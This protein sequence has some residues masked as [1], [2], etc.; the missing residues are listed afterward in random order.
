M[1]IKKHIKANMKNTFLGLVFLATA[2]AAHAQSWTNRYAGSVDTWG[3]A[4]A[5]DSSGNAIVTGRVDGTNALTIKY[6]SAGVPLWT[7]RCGGAL[8]SI[9]VDGSGNVFVRSDG[10]VIGKYS[11]S[12][13][14]LWT[15]RYEGSANENGVARCSAVDGK[16][17]VVVTGYSGGDGNYFDFVTIKYSGSGTALWTNRYDGPANKGD[18]AEYVAV[19]SS[20]NV[21][22]TGLTWNIDHQ[23]NLYQENTTI[24][25]SPTG[26]SLWTNTHNMAPDGLA[27][28]RQGNALVT[29]HY[30]GDCVTVKYSGDGV[31]LWTNRYMGVGEDVP[32][33]GVIV[34]HQDNVIIAGYSW[35][36]REFDYLTIKYSAAGVPLWTNFCGFG[37]DAF[38]NDI[39]VDGSGNV[40]LTGQYDFATVGYSAG[41]APLWTNRYSPLNGFGKAIVAD[42]KG[43]VFVTGSQHNDWVTIKYAAEAAAPYL[44]IHRLGNNFVLS[45]TNAAFGLQSAP[46]I[47]ATFT[48]VP[49]A[50]SP[51]TNTLSGG[52]RFFR[53]ISN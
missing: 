38:G 20:G 48:N 39:A 16:G 14:L 24:K 29:G 13:V 46:A 35:T 15:N 50:T 27:V 10:F 2:L 34:D 53:L 19:D 42:S 1:K 17:D 43:N 7:N 36:G 25:Y 47:T 44:N 11:S 23:G 32:Q 37:A 12:G 22:V 8:N 6:S 18:V 31:S 30:Y 52:Q 5:V 26:E 40:F 28:D 51:Y 4:I 9:A 45:W 3:Q 41:G 21:F 49:G 33:A